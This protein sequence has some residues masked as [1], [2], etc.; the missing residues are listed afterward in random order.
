MAAAVSVELLVLPEPWSGDLVVAAP[1]TAATAFLALV[2]LMLV[3]GVWFTILAAPGVG[4]VVQYQVPFASVQAILS[5][6]MPYVPAWA[7]TVPNGSAKSAW[8]LVLL[9]LRLVSAE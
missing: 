7:I 5:L 6:A 2:V 9:R 4:L 1:F 3:P 8:P